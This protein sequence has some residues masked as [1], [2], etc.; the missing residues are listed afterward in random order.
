MV[1]QKVRSA[2]RAFSNS[3]LEMY[4]VLL[5]GD[6]ADWLRHLGPE[7]KLFGENAGKVITYEISDLRR[8]LT[9]DTLEEAK[10]KAQKAMN[11]IKN[12]LQVGNFFPETS[13]PK[14]H[15]VVIDYGSSTR[16]FILV[17]GAVAKMLP[18][19][20]EVHILDLFPTES[21][22]TPSNILTERIDARTDILTYLNMPALWEG[23]SIYGKQIYRFEPFFTH[24]KLVIAVASEQIEAYIKLF[25]DTDDVRTTKKR[26]IDGQ[27][28]NE[29]QSK[30]LET[31]ETALQVS[32]L[33][34]K[35][36]GGSPNPGARAMFALGLA[37]CVA[38]AIVGS[39]TS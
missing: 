6:S 23:I 30:K 38:S 25:K 11:I 26:V 22:I 4:D 1:A 24:E 27:S 2:M 9:G 33:L 18:D 37:V 7:V 8:E 15:V 34:R 5:V 20:K 35:A 14:E 31:S 29:V 39:I 28:V 12:D 36:D 17:A 32:A 16:S 21:D 13:L 10:E 19:D 3:F